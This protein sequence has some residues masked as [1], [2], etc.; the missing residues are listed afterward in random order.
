MEN[1]GCITKMKIDVICKKMQNI[2]F[3]HSYKHFLEIN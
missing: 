1:I 2:G 3:S